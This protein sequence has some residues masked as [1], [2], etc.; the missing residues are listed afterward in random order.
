MSGP[1]TPSS[2]DGAAPEGAPAG[3]E[4]PR[5]DPFVIAHRGSRVRAP[6]NTLP[7][8]DLALRE[9][10]AEGLELDVQRSRDGEVVVLHDETVDRTTDGHGRADEHSLDE[11]RALD[12][13]YRFVDED[14]QPSWRGRGVRIPTLAEILERYPDTWISIDLKQG[15]PRTEARTLELLRAARCVH[16][17][18]VSAE[19]PSAAS[20]LRRAAPEFEAFFD[21]RS[22][23]RFYLRHRLHCWWGYR[24]PAR[25]LQ[26]PVRHGSQHLD[27]RR[28]IEDAHRLGIRVRYWTVNDET[29]M[30]RLIDLGAD[31]IITDRPDRLVA[32]LKRKGRR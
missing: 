30:E 12:A 8:F 10:G 1:I 4:R 11:L 5:K 17:V 7:A 24:P 21:R 2:E 20:R 13:G 22:V 19:D 25:S 6:E 29:T 3:P 9:D 14:G 15:D 18:V 16:R 31:G 26:I 23:R 28:L 32:V 27:R